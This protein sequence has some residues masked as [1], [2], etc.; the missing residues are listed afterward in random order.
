MR[1]LRSVIFVVFAT[2]AALVYVHQQIEL[3]KLSYSIEYKER[4]LRD[5]LDRRES[6]GY[7]INNLESPGRLE[8]VL[9]SRNIDVSFPKKGSIVR[10]AKLPYKLNGEDRMRSAFKDAG[11]NLFG[12]LDFF[13]PRAEAQARER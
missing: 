12:F 8:K 3:V 11:F 13:N 10:M 6:L 2:L 7:N 5:V 9:T 4:K 1:L